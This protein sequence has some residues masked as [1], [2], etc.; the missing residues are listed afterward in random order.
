MNIHLKMSREVAN[1]ILPPGGGVVV[2]FLRAMGH[3]VIFRVPNDR[4]GVVVPGEAEHY[5]SHCPD[6]G[7]VGHVAYLGPD[8]QSWT[9]DR[10]SSRHKLR[11]VLH[12]THC[13]GDDYFECIWCGVGF[14]RRELSAN[15]DEELAE[16]IRYERKTKGNLVVLQERG[17]S[18][19]PRRRA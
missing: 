10:R 1:R 7:R 3:I 14:T 6:C 16:W 2:H 4:G 5:V 19:P 13:S 11:W 17:A 12:G 8:Y 18:A 9:R 15:F